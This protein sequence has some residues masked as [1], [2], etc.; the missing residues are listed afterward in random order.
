MH[1][2][3]T[4]LKRLGAGDPAKSLLFIAALLVAALEMLVFHHLAPLE[5]RVLDTLVRYHAAGQQ[6]D[7]EI[8]IV[9]IDDPSFAR[10]NDV[11]GNWPWP[12]S[13]HGELV[14]GMLRQHPKA[15]VFD[16]MFSERDAYR[17][18]S[19]RLFNEA[20]AGAGKIYFPIVR[21]AAERDPTGPRADQVAAK[22]GFE[23]L[24]GADGAA[25]IAL[26]PPLAVD[27]R[28]WRTGTINFVEDGD[29]V[30]RRYQLYTNAHGWLIPSLP[31]RVAADLGYPVP[32]DADML[33]SW[34]GGPKAF[35][36]I[37]YADLYQDFSREK[38][39]RPADELTGKI[40]IIGTDASGL[41]DL[42][43]TPVA[44]LYPA[45]QILA[46]A[47]DNLKNQRP[48]RVPPQWLMP[49][50]AL[51]ALAILFWSL[52]RAFNVLKV[53]GALLVFSAATLAGTYWGITRLW[54]VPAVAALLL[55]WTYYFAGALQAYLAERKSRQKA[56]AMF[57]RF[58]NPHVVQQLVTTGGLLRGGESREVSVL[59]S[60]IR[61]FTT[62]SENRTPQQVVALLNRYFTLQVEVVFRH[63]GSLDKFIGDCIMAFWGAPLDDAEHA[64][65]AVRA[66]LE[67]AQVL[68]RFK[69]ELGEEDADFDVGIGIHSGPA[70]VGLIGSEQRREYTA[71]GDTVNLASRIEG[72][73]KGV[74]RILVSEET[75]D[76]CG[77]AFQFTSY[78]SFEVK[79][80]EQA[81]NLFGPEKGR[82]K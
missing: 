36:H 30:G 75:K 74:A 26:L 80:R 38:A 66:A 42:R 56:I 37:Q 62:L 7:P 32:R 34:R 67:M 81:V 27:E 49:A 58:V 82:E 73:T 47:I 76:L 72:L 60:D 1:V 9:D 77:T 28:Y 21:L 13:V 45:V 79:G 43:A 35:P 71:I 64:Q 54:L 40:V 65:N 25:R 48:M 11:A 63:G 2:F 39:L 3:S 17:P 24:P 20:L 50:L 23:P 31:A 41:N 22:L 12:R 10:M 4:F 8:V 69:T 61:G 78:G 57:S 68:Q 53:G 5:N 46:T 44:T 14:Q 16:L 59:F 70:V 18:D 33:L 51:L 6:P 55:A 52:E 15:I 19:D 29:G